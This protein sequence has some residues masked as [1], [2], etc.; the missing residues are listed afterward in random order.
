MSP[1][2]YAIIAIY[3]LATVGVGLYFY[4]RHQSSASYFVG[5]RSMTSGHLGMSI[6]ATD[7]G[8]GFSIGLGGLGFTM[9][10]SGSWLLFTGLVGAWLSA[11]LVIPIVKPLADRH[12]WLT[13][14]DLLEHRFDARVRSLAAGVS[15]LGY[16]GFVGA[17]VLAGSKLAAATTGVE[18]TQAV[19]IIALIVVG[20]TALGGLTA[21]VFTDSIQWGIL[22]I[23]LG[24]IALPAAIIEAGGLAAIAA[25]LPAGHLSLT[26]VSFGQLASWAVTII[27]IWFVGMTL[28]QRMYAAKD[29]RTAKRAWFLAGLLEWPLMAF[30]GAA[31]GMIARVLFPEVDP[32]MGVPLLVRDVLPIGLTGL[33]LA[34]YFSAIMSTADSCLLASVG[35]LIGDV[36][37]R[38]LPRDQWETEA[39][40]RHV[41]RW[42]RILTLLVG[43][44]SCAIALYTPSVLDAILGA[45]AFMVSGLFVPTLAALYWP[46]ATAR[47][48]LAS[49]VVGGGLAL[50]L[51]AFDVPLGGL[52]PIFI[53]ILG[54]I[55]ALVVGSL[56]GRR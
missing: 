14:P 48:A 1:L 9:G 4:R 41:L 30:A 43:F 18:P 56:M 39:V 34:A 6:V 27:P 52:E 7:V 15:A 46:G 8:G 23:G 51:P 33:V 45:Y 17:Q 49:M 36:Y 42:S 29:V 19:A 16:A 20:Y 44:G 13:Y 55:V 37:L 3:L 53:A 10:L 32:E 28:Y 26:S 5:D 24:A 38:R 40:Q 50:G 12:G 22:A 21:V 31:L 2:D 35:H 54:A 11:V 25:A 47:G